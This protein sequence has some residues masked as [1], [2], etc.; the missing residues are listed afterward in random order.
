[1]FPGILLIDRQ[2][3][4][5]PDIYQPSGIIFTQ[6]F[7]RQLTERIL[8]HPALKLFFQS[9]GL[10]RL[11]QQITGLDIYEPGGHFE[12]IGCLL[13]VFDICSVDISKILLQQQAYLDVVNIQFVL[14]NKMEQQIQRPFKSLQLELY[15]LHLRKHRPGDRV[16]P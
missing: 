5:C 11:R 4:R 9:L 13:I 12:K 8:Q 7:S 3:Y 6:T 2:L 14:G 16:Y 1:M 15:A 10:F